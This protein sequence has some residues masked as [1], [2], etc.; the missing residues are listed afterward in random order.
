M[1]RAARPKQILIVDPDPVE[2]LRL[3]GVISGLGYRGVTGGV[4]EALS[5]ARSLRFHL[6]L[7][8][9]AVAPDGLARLADHLHRAAV[10]VVVLHAEGETPAATPGVT[11]ALKKPWRTNDLL[12]TLYRFAG[13][14]EKER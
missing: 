13:A 6:A 12:T 1:P 9:A 2:A 5:L 14:P 3:R 11:G 10:P 4:D 7:V 8:D